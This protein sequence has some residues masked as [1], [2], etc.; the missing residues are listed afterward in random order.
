VTPGANPTYD[1]KLQRQRFKKI[2]NA[3]SSLVRFENKYGFYY[4]EKRSSLG[5]TTLAL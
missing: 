3:T 4:F 5:T 1:R 2:Y